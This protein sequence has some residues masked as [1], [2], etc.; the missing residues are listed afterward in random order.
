MKEDCCNL[1]YQ[2][3]FKFLY[4]Y[5]CHRFWFISPC[6]SSGCQNGSVHVWTLPQGGAVVS[7]PNILNSPTQ[8]DKSSDVKVSL[9]LLL[10][11]LCSFVA[12]IQEK[13]WHFG[14]ITSY[15]DFMCQLFIWFD[16]YA[17]KPPAANLW[18]V[19]M[20][21]LDLFATVA[22]D[23]SSCN[24]PVLFLFTAGECKVCVCTSWPHYSSEV[25]F[26]LLQWTGSGLWRDRGTA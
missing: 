2:H 3:Y 15:Q 26:V 5:V 25:P 17:V 10:E 18:F 14:I 12:L 23:F 9:D 11:L 19:I 22:S 20:D 7:L 1:I 21:W 6:F 8:Q 24:H 4:S 16:L 13:S